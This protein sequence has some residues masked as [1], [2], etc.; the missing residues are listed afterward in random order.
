MSIPKNDRPQITGP[1][2]HYFDA[3]PVVASRP[4][5]VHLHV[6]ELALQLQA[7]RGVFGSRGVDLG[8][9]ALLIEA[10]APPPEG[11]IL[12]LGSGYGPIEIALARQ[13]TR[14]RVWALDV[15]ERA[16]VLKTTNSAEVGWLRWPAAQ[17]KKGIPN[18]AGRQPN[19]LTSW[20]DRPA[21]RALKS[22]KE[23]R[24][25]RVGLE[26]GRARQTYAPHP[27]AET[28]PTSL[29]Q[30]D[31]LPTGPARHEAPAAAPAP[32]RSPA[33]SRAAAGSGAISGY[34]SLNPLAGA[35]RGLMLWAWVETSGAAP[36]APQASSEGGTAGARAMP[37]GCR[38]PP[39]ISCGYRLVKFGLSPASRS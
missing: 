28:R 37:L 22:R 13:Y 4:R 3:A 12:D 25:G 32:S 21:F 36:A 39:G 23:R 18:P 26:E 7:D 29:P 20:V 1:K 33:P 15:H 11:D 8:T 27:D 38:W 19:V 10:P 16:I 9:R 17:V 35:G 24:R 30:S 5:T 31:T 14:A 6:G 2:S 34:G